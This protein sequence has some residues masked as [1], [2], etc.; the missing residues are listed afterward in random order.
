METL[1]ETIEKIIPYVDEDFL[2]FPLAEEGNYTQFLNFWQLAKTEK[3]AEKIEKKIKKFNGENKKY[4]LDVV[5]P[6]MGVG[7][8]RLSISPRFETAEDGSCD[9][10]FEGWSVEE[11]ALHVAAFVSKKRKNEN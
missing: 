9:Y 8:F 4:C 11:M 6:V 7:V 2:T 1:R 3:E 5:E 10:L